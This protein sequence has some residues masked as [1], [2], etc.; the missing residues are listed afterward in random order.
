MVTHRRQRH[1]PLA[2]AEAKDRNLWPAQS[3]FD[4][5]GKLALVTGSSRGIGRALAQ[6]LTD[7]A[8][9]AGCKTTA[10]IT[11]MNQPLVPSLGNALEV[12]EIMRI[13]DSVQ[14]TAKEQ[15]ASP[16]NWEQGDEVVIVPAV[17]DDD[18]KKK[19]PDGWKA[20]KP[21]MRFVAQPVD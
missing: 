20:P 2:V 8:N 13:L 4:L 11:D 6:A 3:L 9:A 7:T 12:A 1:H 19:Y 16:V 14:L 5:T 21:Y 17:S 18:A 15:V 10:V